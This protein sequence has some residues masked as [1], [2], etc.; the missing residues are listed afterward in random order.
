MLLSRIIV[1]FQ[2]LPRIRVY[3]VCISRLIHVHTYAHSKFGHK[4][5]TK[6]AHM[7]IKVIF[8]AK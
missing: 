4:I 3:T 5:T 8:F 1:H 2:F 7:Q 6:I